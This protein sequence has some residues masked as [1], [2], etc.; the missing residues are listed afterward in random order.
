MNQ[1]IKLLIY[2]LLMASLGYGISNVFTKAV[3]EL[4]LVVVMAILGLMGLI[5][6]VKPIGEYLFFYFSLCSMIY[7]SA[8][9]FMQGSLYVTMLFLS[10]L[11]FFLTFPKKR[12]SGHLDKGE[13]TISEQPHSMV[14]EP[15]SGVAENGESN[16]NKEPSTIKTFSPG[17]Y[18]A[19][20]NG[21]VFHA[22]TCNWA[23]KVSKNRQIWLES[24]DDAKGKGYKAHNCIS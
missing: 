16:E 6:W 1:P 13:P 5:F 12:A 24:K 11:M 22:P 14:F 23:R 20:S 21:L 17:L 9:W 15:P 19:S 7:F 10:V 3:S 2:I 18:V 8:V 4:L